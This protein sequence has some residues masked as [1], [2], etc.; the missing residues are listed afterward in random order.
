MQKNRVRIADMNLA[1]EGH[2]RIEWAWEYMPVLRLIA[3]EGRKSISRL[4]VWLSD[5]VCILRLRRPAF[6]K[7]MHRL[8]ATV[9]VAGSNPLSTGHNMRCAC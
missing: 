5:A 7:V 2:R 3:E 6:L 8:G 9:A 4:K 1:P